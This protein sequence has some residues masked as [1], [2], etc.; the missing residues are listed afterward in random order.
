MFILEAEASEKSYMEVPLIVNL[1]QFSTLY[2]IINEK[3]YFQYLY[4]ICKYT[5]Y[6]PYSQLSPIN[7]INKPSD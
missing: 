6:K 1:N 7:C 4:C 5:L 2:K 3:T